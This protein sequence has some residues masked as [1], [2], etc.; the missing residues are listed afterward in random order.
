MD[1][2]GKKLVWKDG[3]V[4]RIAGSVSKVETSGRDMCTIGN[5]RSR[6]RAGHGDSQRSKL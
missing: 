4:R 3:F 6:S 1:I 2:V 5:K